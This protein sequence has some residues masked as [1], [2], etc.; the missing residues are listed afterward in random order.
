MLGDSVTLTQLI[1]GTYT[2]SAGTVSALGNT[3]TATLTGSPATLAAGT[4]GQI[5]VSYA[6]TIAPGQATTVTGPP[7][8]PISLVVPATAFPNGARLDIEPAPSP[9][10]TAPTGSVGPAFEIASSADPQTPVELRVPYDSS[11]NGSAAD[12]QLGWWSDDTNS[13]RTVP[14]DFDSSNN[15]LVTRIL[16]FLG[17]VV[18]QEDDH[19]YRGEQAVVR[20]E[21]TLVG[22]RE[23]NGSG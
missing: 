16:P 5:T 8:A 11:A 6:I 19:G 20:C 10:P 22:A 13:W 9:D 21:P 17:V 14:T 15:V 4:N 2:V 12:V 1:P 23:S 3:Y 18:D 7:D